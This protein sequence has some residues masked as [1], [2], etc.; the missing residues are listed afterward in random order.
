MTPHNETYEE[1]VEEKKELIDQ[2]FRD[3]VTTIDKKGKRNFLF[4]K[5]PKGN[6]YRWRTIAS[7]VY[8]V[9]FFGLP[10]IKVAGQPLF[11]FN[12][13]E[14][15]FILFGQIFW[16]QDFFIFAIGLITFIVFVIVFTV[17]FGRVFCGWACPQTVFM[18]MVFRKIEYWLD[19]SY[20]IFTT[21]E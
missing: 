3:S 15:K 19:G 14:R 2:S 17:V 8:L 5:K 16:P 1:L 11:L 6:L 20:F 9:I 18:E 10:F 7:L 13:L 21:T 4:P 12:V